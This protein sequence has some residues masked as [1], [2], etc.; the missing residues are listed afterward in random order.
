MVGVAQLQMW[1]CRPNQKVGGL[2]KWGHRMRLFLNQGA[3]GNG[4]RF[5]SRRRQWV[6]TPG[7]GV[8]GVVWQG[9]GVVVLRD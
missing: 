2:D 5:R 4:G 7:K 1:V 8:V 3:R 6:R 9:A